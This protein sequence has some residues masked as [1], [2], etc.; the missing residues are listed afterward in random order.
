MPNNQ[1][2]KSKMAI[3]Q[4]IGIPFV[5]SEYLLSQHLGKVYAGDSARGIQ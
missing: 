4:S 3:V 1:R 2:I 5:E